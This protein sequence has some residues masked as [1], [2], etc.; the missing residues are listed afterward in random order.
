M[1][2][3]DP[4]TFPKLWPRRNRNLHETLKRAE[5]IRPRLGVTQGGSSRKDSGAKP[6]AT[7]GLKPSTK[8]T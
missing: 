6:A 5:F 2:E 4:Y 3:R 7:R 8:R 1:A